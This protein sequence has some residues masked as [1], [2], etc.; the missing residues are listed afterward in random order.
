MAKLVLNDLTNITGQETSAIAQINDNNQ[1]I[2]EAIENTLSLDGTSP[3]AMNADFDMNGNDILNVGFING[4]DAN[5]LTGPEGPE[6]PQGDTG[7]QGDPG[8]PGTNGNDGVGIADAEV[9]GDDLIIT[10]TDA[11]EI[12]AGDV[13]GPQGD[14][15]IQGPQGEPG[16]DGAGTVASVAAGTGIDVDATDPNNPIINVDVT[17]IFT[18]SVTEINYTDGVT[19]SIQTQL[20]AKQPL[21]SDLTTIAGL[22]ATTDNFIQSK[23]SAWTSRTPTQVTADLITMVGDS[24]SGGTKGL[25]PAPSAGDAAASKFLKADGT[26]ATSTGFADVDRRNQLLLMSNSAKALATYQRFLDGLGIGFKA[27]GDADVTSTTGSVD[28]TAGAWKP[29]MTGGLDANALLLLHMDGSNGSTTFTDSSASAR[30]VTPSGNV[31]ISTAQ[32][33][34]GGA[35]ALFAGTGDWL[36]V[37]D[38]ADWNFGTSNFTI[39]LRFRCT[40][41]A[42]TQGICG[43]WTDGNNGW[44][45]VVSTAG[46][47]TF[48]QFVSSSANI[49]VS[50]AAAA[51]AINTWYHLA[52]VRNGTN[53]QLYKDGVSIASITDA[54]SIGNYSQVF[55]IGTSDHAGT[56][57]MTGNIDEF[58]ISNIARWTSG[59][60]PQA[61]AYLTQADNGTLITPYQTA[62]A[63]RTKVRGIFEIDPVDAITLGTDWTVEYT[64]NG[65]TNWT[66]A[67]TYT[68]CG[69]GQSGRTVVE[70]EEVTCTSGTSFAARVKNLNN[71]D[72]HVYKAALKAAT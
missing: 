51:I 60:T 67:S 21:D 57:P 62:D 64:C 2:E 14:Q 12:N 30:T 45:L 55:R 34:F 25:V 10:L 50:S 8:T 69:K 72:V 19:S 9:V 61:F 7:P 49:T 26:W 18:A 4:Q 38:S 29:S 13:R 59:F 40:S 46:V 44:R 68:D 63:A 1:H 27:S 52:L 17:E 54:D 47:L 56:F 22:T 6:G 16:L 48:E 36:S 66:A 42:T 23:S 53:F 31:Q 35:S 33:V 11:T 28:T 37:P 20:D 5:D 65:G 58:R 43:H 15:G 39:D 71:K 32:S 3:N 24:G 41:L 70:T